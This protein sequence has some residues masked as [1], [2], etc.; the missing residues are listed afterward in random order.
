MKKLMLLGTVL[1]TTFAFAQTFTLKT[2]ETLEFKELKKVS[3]YGSEMK[4]GLAKPFELKLAA[5]T[6]EFGQNCEVTVNE[7][8]KKILSGV[9]GKEIKFEV[10]GQ[11]IVFGKGQK[12]TLSSDGKSIS[13]AGIGKEYQLKIQGGTLVFKAGSEL[14]ID[15]K[16]KTVKNGVLAKECAV[17]ID[18]RTYPFAKDKKI[19]LSSDCKSVSSGVLSRDTLF[20]Y[21]GIKIPVKG[22][23]IPA[24]AVPD[25]S[26]SF[27]FGKLNTVLAAK[28]FEAKIGNTVIPAKGLKPIQVRK[29]KKEYIY[30]LFSSKTVTFTV[31][32]KVKEYKGVTGLDFDEEGNF[33][34]MS[35]YQ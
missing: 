22:G 26:V 34:G 20:E 1:F 14:E 4:G 29:N 35:K 16:Q 8:Q 11:E 30:S 28:D 2:G 9:L 31:Q 7:S 6:V 3:K 24:D 15:L 10:N 12:V 33:I 23:D 25:Y 27:M 32:G 18:G 19:F 5:V 17:E 21:A 13:K